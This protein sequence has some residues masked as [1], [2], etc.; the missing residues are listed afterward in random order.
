MEKREKRQWKWK[1]E[2]G[3]VDRGRKKDKKGQR[4][5]QRDRQTDREADT[6]T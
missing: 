5:K 3:E 2:R 4:K 1:R 6:Q